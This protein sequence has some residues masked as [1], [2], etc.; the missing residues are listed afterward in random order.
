MV[1]HAREVAVISSCVRIPAVD[2]VAGYGMIDESRR[3]AGVGLGGSRFLW[4]QLSFRIL[5]GLERSIFCSVFASVCWL[6][7]QEATPFVWR[8]GGAGIM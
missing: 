8:E 4:R 7:V 3:C 6:R 5:I 2:K 1:R